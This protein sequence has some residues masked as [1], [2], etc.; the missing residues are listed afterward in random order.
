[1]K[2]RS[3][4]MIF[5]GVLAFGLLTGC[6]SAAET[7]DVQIQEVSGEDD[8]D[9]NNEGDEEDAQDVPDQETE[10][11]PEAYRTLNISDWCYE[12]LAYIN[13]DYLMAKSDGKYVIIDSATG[14]RVYDNH[15]FDS[16]TLNLQDG[17]FIG[18]EN[19]DDGTYTSQIYYWSNNELRA[20]IGIKNKDAKLVDYRDGIAVLQK[21]DGSFA[22]ATLNSEG[23]VHEGIPGLKTENVFISYGNVLLNHSAYY[24]DIEASDWMDAA[25]DVKALI[26]GFNDPGKTVNIHDAEQEGTLKR[27]LL[28][29]EE[30]AVDVWP[31]T[32]ND[33]GWITA[34]LW[35]KKDN[36]EYDNMYKKGFYNVKTG[37]FIEYTLTDEFS[38]QFFTVDN[39]SSKCTVTGSK[40]LVKVGQD[41]NG[42]A[43]RRIYDLK[44]R[45]WASEKY[46]NGV[47]AFG[48]GKY[49]LAKSSDG[50]WGYINSEDMSETEWFDY[51]SEFCNGYA[52]V[53]N[54][55]KAHL[56]NEKF[57]QVSEEFEA[58]CADAAT[59]DYYEFSDLDGKSVF[60]AKLPDGLYHMVTVE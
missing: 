28:T 56:I 37:E 54:N 7:Q 26:D 1:M 10:E 36:D 3:L 32:P 24:K 12:A 41:D 6:G 20:M 50:K 31:N 59:K 15:S 17:R 18:V 2:K 22:L 34:S 27:T 30:K 52:I 47:M 51:A 5:A 33:E 46:Y 35:V 60:F 39:G 21:G 44:T 38:T 19:N 25:A 13:R 58:N 53:I 8:I 14:E 45:N 11:E 29:Y 42:A 4:A 48:Y 23:H 49:V 40:A 9:E 16:V 43:I 55:G 57:E